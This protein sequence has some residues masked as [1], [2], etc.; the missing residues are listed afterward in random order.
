MDVR[1]FIR[2]GAAGTGGGIVFRHD[3]ENIGSRSLVRAPFYV[4]VQPAT[5]DTINL[6]ADLD[7][8]STGDK[9]TVLGGS[10]P[11]ADDDSSY[12]YVTVRR[13]FG[14]QEGN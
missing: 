12:T 10:N 1:I 9:I 14:G 2:I 5:G 13:S 3:F 4:L 7:N 8:T 11:V 6:T